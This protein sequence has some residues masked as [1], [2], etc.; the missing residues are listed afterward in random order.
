MPESAHHDAAGTALNDAN[1]AAQLDALRRREALLVAGQELAGL[2]TLEWHVLE[3][4]IEW[5]RS[6]EFLLGPMPAGGYPLI[7]EMV[8]PE[9][10]P[11]WLKERDRALRGEGPGP[12]EFRLLR[13]DGELRW[14][15]H[16]QRP[17]AVVDGRTTRVTIA[18][19]DIT[20][21]RDAQD[22]ATRLLQDAVENLEES[23]SLCDPEGRYV[24]TNRRFRQNNAEIA[25]FIRP[26]YRYEDAVRAAIGKGLFLDAIGREDAWIQERLAHRRERHPSAIEQ[27]RKDDRWILI[28]ETH[29][30][31]GSVITLGLDI[32]ERKRAEERLQHFSEQLEKRVA[33]RSAELADREALLRLVTS[34]VPVGIAYYDRARRLKFANQFYARSMGF[35]DAAPLIGRTLDELFPA[36]VL[37]EYE[38]YIERALR[39]EV[40]RYEA[41]RQLDTLRTGENILVPEKS[42][43]GAVVG[44]FVAVVD[45]TKR[46]RAELDLAGRETLLR[47]VTENIPIK[48]IYWDA[49][50]R[51]LFANPQYAKAL[52]KA[53][54]AEV[55]GKTIPELIPAENW[56]AHRPYFDRALAGEGVRYE[57]T[58]PVGNSGV[59][60]IHLVPDVGGDGSIR[61]VFATI[62]DISSLKTAQQE[63]RRS[64]SLLEATL[65]STA[66][67]LLVVSPD[68]RI[69]SF[70]RRFVQLWGIP[71]PVLES[72]DDHRAI[73]FVLG[74]LADPAAFTAKVEALYAHPEAESFDVLH[75]KD[76]RVFERYSRPQQV[77]GAVVGR[78]WSFRDVTARARAEAA[79]HEL[80]AEL[81]AR[82]A[83]RTADLA[84][85]NRELEAF[86][87][88][89]SHDLRAP[90]RAVAGF[91]QILL[92]DH[93]A[94]LDE[95]GRRLLER[96]SAAGERMGEMIDGLLRLARVSRAELARAPLDLSAM[97]RTVWEEVAATEPGRRVEFRATEGLRTHAD[98]VLVRNVLQNLLGN[99]FKYT[100][101]KAH[102][103]VE[104]CTMDA[105]GK[106]AY[107]IRDNGVGFD[108][109]HAGKLFGVFQRV[110]GYDEFEGTGVGLAT[111]QRI[112]A[113]HG[114]R[115]WADARLGQGAT[116][117]FT[118]G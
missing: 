43:D 21:R 7:R 57:Y 9:D 83:M 64:L 18:L 104:F 101:P 93:A 103:S 48:I 16:V 50:G 49:T 97:A 15:A 63:L 14:I 84:L 92:A 25:E 109:A 58:A 42:A 77:E 53:S 55:I 105:D 74:Q 99:A 81:E 90:A 51:T 34:N 29:L 108:M 56:A 112:V 35:D 32:T 17:S 40:V 73:E 85:A 60:D 115:I 46:K 69:S 19:L 22:R 6:P 13:T 45:I 88:T 80:N 87:Y 38:P 106:V 117:C 71:H 33:E 118:L 39:G 94:Q 1:P 44:V 3:D 37:A 5:S 89:V 27:H 20:A 98:P 4:R 70:N 107:C 116:F 68:G 79:V 30:A 114:G 52:G 72:R 67:G 91:S 61:G 96:M 31:D 28:R 78:V 82:V 47:L 26:G 59:L 8:H 12:A 23:F 102:G 24:V 2:V 66:D 10:R 113:R 65:E 111:A 110:H 11:V 54:V 100:R 95:D 86:S 62:V 75:F 36:A 41:S 76:G